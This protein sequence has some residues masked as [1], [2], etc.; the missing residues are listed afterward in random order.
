MYLVISEDV[1]I[2]K[3]SEAIKEKPKPAPE[4]KV[5][6]TDIVAWYVLKLKTN[7][8]FTQIQWWY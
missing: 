7:L 3:I 1:Y 2:L 6:D 8:K 5:R 4:K